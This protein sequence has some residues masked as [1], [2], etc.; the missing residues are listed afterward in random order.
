MQEERDYERLKYYIFVYNLMNGK[1]AYAA[2][3][4]QGWK[5]FWVAYPDGAW[6][7]VLGGKIAIGGF[8][9]LQCQC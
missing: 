8:L 4:Q 1:V 6:F 9:H 2:L 7:K 3:L 5:K